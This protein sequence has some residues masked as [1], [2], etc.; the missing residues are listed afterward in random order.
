MP[1]WSHYDQVA[2]IATKALA[3]GGRRVSPGLVE[4]DIGADCEA[5]K[6]VFLVGRKEALFA[7]DKWRQADQVGQ[8]TLELNM[9]TRCRQCRKCLAHRAS[10]WRGRM[11]AEMGMASRTWFG[12][13]TLRP[14]AH[15]LAFRKACVRLTRSA[16]DFDRLSEREQFA[17]RCKEIS[18]E[19][20]RYLKRVRKNSGAAVR[21]IVVSEAH[22]SGLPHF[23]ALIHEY[24]GSV[25]RRLLD[26][27]W[28]LGFTKWR[29]AS[30]ERNEAAYL[31]KYLSK[32]NIARVRASLRYGQGPARSP[33]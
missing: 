26:A 4:W 31:A 18:P 16:V 6:M 27:A 28:P 13:L 32:S 15:E 23:H 12:T 5:P 29:L 25:E 1:R 19:I 10:L 9:W 21:H 2:R 11:R 14:D 24:G 8:I 3:K 20:T 7:D 30:D 33:Q 17:E 22:Q